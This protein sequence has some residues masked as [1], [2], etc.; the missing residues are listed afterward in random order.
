M[1]APFWI[2]GVW[3]RTPFGFSANPG[4]L[5]WPSTWKVCCLN[6]SPISNSNEQYQCHQASQM[7]KSEL[8]PLSKSNLQSLFSPLKVHRI[9]IYPFLSA[10]M[11]CSWPLLTMAAL[12]NEV[13]ISFCIWTAPSLRNSRSQLSFCHFLINIENKYSSMFAPANT[14]GRGT[15]RFEGFNQMYIIYITNVYHT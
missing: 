1:N 8:L 10:S 15:L 4:D 7:R 12:W 3:R 2:V 14:M 6:Q 5:I 11:F 13:I 9:S